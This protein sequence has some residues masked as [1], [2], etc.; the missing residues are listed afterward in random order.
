VVHTRATVSPVQLCG[1]AFCFSLRLT[2]RLSCTTTAWSAVVGGLAGFL[3]RSPDRSTRARTTSSH[4]LSPS[5]TGAGGFHR[6]EP[7]RVPAQLSATTE[8]LACGK[9]NQKL[10][11]PPS[12]LMT[13]IVP[14]CCSTIALQIGSPSPVPRLLLSPGPWARGPAHT[15]QRCCEG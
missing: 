11:P 3:P 9:Q 5:S 8:A 15:S 1:Q 7:T 6:P 2:T 4:Q 13:P 14:P 10:L 12:V